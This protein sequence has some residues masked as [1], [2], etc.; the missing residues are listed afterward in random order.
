MELLLSDATNTSLSCSNRIKNLAAKYFA[1]PSTLDVLDE[2]L[3]LLI[4]AQIRR[5]FKQLNQTLSGMQRCELIIVFNFINTFHE[6]IHSLIEHSN[7]EHMQRWANEVASF[8][9]LEDLEVDHV[10][11]ARANCNEGRLSF[12]LVGTPC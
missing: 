11:V 2:S 1:L 6:R 10:G 9:E 5:R 4:L 12:L 8:Q 7:F 3:V